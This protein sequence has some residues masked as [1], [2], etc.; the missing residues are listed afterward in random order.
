MATSS[1]DSSTSSGT[2]T[3][4]ALS[5]RVSA[6]PSRNAARY[7]SGTVATPPATATAS[8]ITTV[9]RN[10]CAIPMTRRRST[11]SISTPL[12]SPNSSQGSWEANATPATSAGLRV[13][14]A[15]S[16]GSAAWRMPSE[17]FDEAVAAHSRVKSAPSRGLA[18]AFSA[19]VELAS[20][21]KSSRS[22][23][24]WS[25]VLYSTE[26]LHFKDLPTALRGWGD[27]PS[28]LVRRFRRLLRRTGVCGSLGSCTPRSTA[29]SRLTPTSAHEGPSRVVCR[30]DLPWTVSGSN[31]L[32]LNGRNHLFLGSQRSRAYT[33]RD[34]VFLPVAHRDESGTSH[35]R[36][37]R[38]SRRR[39]G[40][41]RRQWRAAARC[42]RRCPSGHPR[43]GAGPATNGSRR[44]PRREAGE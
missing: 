40:P 38:L 5:K 20:E 23:A 30:S 19:G 37:T 13:S 42:G 6:V 10:R 7:T 28:S 16:S 2:M 27:L 3:C 32:G 22:G 14:E 24:V 26:V 35:M 36:H 29:L 33:R 31:R 25:T 15:T 18:G 21:K 11:R 1:C 39:C 44:T 12:A 4:A 34:V 17:R 41:V 43:S 9:M 8:R